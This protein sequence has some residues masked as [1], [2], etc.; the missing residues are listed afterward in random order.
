MLMGDFT[1]YMQA[2]P[3]N[4]SDPSSI[5]VHAPKKSGLAVAALISGAVGVITCCTAIPSV[6][7]IVFG[8][9]ALP[10][11][12][13]RES[14]G[15]GMAVTGIL[16]GIVG[17]VLGI[18][19][20]VVFL[21]S[22]M[23]GALPGVRVPERHRNTLRQ[24]G[25]LHEGE[26]IELLYTDGFFSLKEGCVVVTDHRLVV[27]SE[28]AL[29]QKCALK[30]I[31]T[32]SFTP[33]VGWSQ[34][35]KFV[36]DLEDGNVVSFGIAGHQDGDQLLY[37]ALNRRVAEE[38]K[39]AGKPAPLLQSSSLQGR[40][41]T[42][43]TRDKGDMMDQP[44]SASSAG[45]VEQIREYYAGMPPKQRFWTATTGILSLASVALLLVYGLFSLALGVLFRVALGA[46]DKLVLGHLRA[47]WLKANGVLLLLAGIASFAVSRVYYHGRVLQP[48]FLVLIGILAVRSGLQ[49]GRQMNSRH[50]TQANNRDNG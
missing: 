32:I 44:A 47:I 40:P 21:M 36:L 39:A 19:V 34:E 6:L 23:A 24:M 50:A 42:Q 31:H 26:E 7:G 41:A 33:K 38:R 1:G 3:P 30:D 2:P 18:V 35:A 28:G 27:F 12:A 8:V 17:L 15:R 48:A 29:S 37:Q 14:S 11:I 9:I 16:L 49:I 25:V 22:P 13:R 43:P 5:P 46:G 10:A 4:P 20:W 45:P